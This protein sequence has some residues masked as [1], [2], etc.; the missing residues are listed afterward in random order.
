MNMPVNPGPLTLLYPQWIPGEHGPTGPV[1]DLVNV[2]MAGGGKAISWRRDLNDMYAF[3][4]DYVATPDSAG[5][6][7]AA[8]TTDKLALLSWKQMLLYPK[9]SPSGQ[10]NYQADLTVPAGWRYASALPIETES[11]RHIQFKP[12]SL[13]TLVDSPVLMGVYFKTVDISLGMA[14]PHY[15]QIAADSEHH[16]GEKY[17][18]LVRDESKPDLL[19]AIVAPHA[20]AKTQ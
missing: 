4:L 18:H 2:R 3:A 12:A 15:L 1:T 9:G 6:S 19:T 11:G 20:T 5:F 7:S 13:T 16:G 8:S 17:P 14:P 10:L